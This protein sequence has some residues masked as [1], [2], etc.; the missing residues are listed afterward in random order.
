MNSMIRAVYIVIL[1]GGFVSSCAADIV[2][3]KKGSSYT[4]DEQQI[5][6]VSSFFGVHARV[7]DID[8]EDAY[9]AIVEFVRSS[10]T[11]ALV[12]REDALG[13][14]NKTR[15]VAGISRLGRNVPPVLIFGVS[16]TTD[17]RQLS[18]WSG[19]SIDGCAAAPKDFT[20]KWLSVGNSVDLAQTLAGQKLPAVV[21]PVCMMHVAGNQAVQ[22][23]LAADGTKQG[24][25]LLVRARVGTAQIFFVPKLRSIDSSWIGRPR[26]LSEAFSSMAPFIFFIKYAAGEYAWH[27]EG[28]YA[29]LTIDDAW[30]KNPYGHLDYRA[31]VREMQQHRFHTTIAFVPWNFD[32]SRTDM[33]E[34]FR[35]HPDLL[36]V[37][38]H[39]ND[40]SHREFGAY[41]D[42]PLDQQVDNIKQ[43]IWRMERFHSLT[44]IPYDR[45][46]VF[47][48]AVAPAM[49]FSAL[50][51]YGFLGTANSENIPLGSPTT[52]NPIF[53]LRPYTL[54]FAN[55]LS[56]F[57]YSAEVPIPRLEI[58]I[59]VFLGN[60]LLFYGH[61]QLFSN[62][63]GAFDRIADNVNEITP[64]VQWTS[65]G[66]LAR[67]LYLVRRQNHDSFE[68]R[69]YSDELTLK[70]VTGQEAFFTIERSYD[71]SVRPPSSI[72]SG[73]PAQVTTKGD[74]LI[75]R[76]RLRPNA[77]LNVKI[78]SQSD[79]NLFHGN[80]KKGG[81]YTSMLRYVSDFRDIYLSRAPGG[82]AITKA[83]YRYGV[84][85][86]E[87][88]MEREWRLLLILLG[89]GL[90]TAAYLVRRLRKRHRS[91]MQPS[92]DRRPGR[93]PSPRA[94]GQP[95]EHHESTPIRACMI[96]YSVYETDTRVMRYAEA[97]S[98]RGDLVDVI[99]L[100]DGKQSS[101]DVIKGIRISRIQRRDS[102]NG[103]KAAYAVGIL[104]F[105]VRAMLL[106]TR[107]HLK[108][109]YQMIHVH[110]VPDFLVFTCW[111]P[112][113][114]GA[115]V[116]LDIHDL[117][118]ELYASKYN[119]R[120]D[121]PLFR[122]LT[123]IER[124]SGTF[125]DHVIAAND[126]WH[127][128]LMLR[129]FP[130]GKCSTL[131]NVPDRSL[132][133]RHGKTR[134]DGKFVILYPGTLNMHQGVDIAIRAFNLIQNELPQA[135]FHI[136]GEGSC[137]GL[138]LK[139][140]EELGLQH[141]VFMHA[142]VSTQEIVKVMENADLAVVP[143]RK[144]GFGGEAFSTKIMEFMALGVPVI[145]SDT[146]VDRYYFS[147]DVVRF[148]ESGNE[149]D[150]AQ[151]ILEIAKNP[152]ESS[153]L[154]ARALTFVEHND[155]GAK[156]SEYLQLADR[157]VYGSP[158]Q[159]RVEPQR[160]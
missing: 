129:S 24:A 54:Q 74:Q 26:E 104:L 158:K 55:F 51:D 139:I 110:S 25:G 10:P 79:L 144:D 62:G 71:S 46:M 33:V 130:N 73:S 39:G 93:G 121:S 63:I 28:Q 123:G 97:L 60:P 137:R 142:L 109:K 160:C 9:R 67:H 89:A 47:P 4:E 115:R 141:Q 6:A 48:H 152:E 50:R 68:I 146:R 64:D 134:R 151:K 157:L 140:I 107:R 43:A 57:R 42:H 155:W 7:I 56:L 72:I 91:A 8:E 145:V 17:A 101:T 116:I 143:K 34:L 75:F 58:A 22:T 65:L 41:T 133:A 125:S 95:R 111:V 106:V 136:Y 118:P 132:F 15:I 76:A 124:A 147:D 150:L 77:V 45:F 153:Q 131:V 23:L 154:A 2:I 35:N 32:R 31:L 102:N 156:K 70:N 99:S 40:H 37:C 113:L 27:A 127:E 80:V 148:F 117:L 94:D 49:T 87:L 5:V 120:I 159:L 29:N 12:V 19:G 3:V 14:L 84:N 114:S 44:G 20:A 119:L 138:L 52:Q 1:L 81:L 112:K 18:S 16:T 66:E 92:K 88:Q 128:K 53:F 98:E 100:R 21:S 105:F 126:L 69:M 59:N 61:Q 38:I 103:T 122:L 36:S 149:H 82:E 108:H 78:A 83:Y 13:A 135:E 86:L 85:A 90:A 11:E 96:T 30:L